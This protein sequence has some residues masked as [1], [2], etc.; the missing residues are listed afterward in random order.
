MTPDMMIFYVSDISSSARFYATVLGQEPQDLSPGFALFLLPNGLKIGLW[1]TGAVAPA[2]SFTGCGA[3]LVLHAA[4]EA[5]VEEAHSRWAAAGLPI[6]DP[7]VGQEFGFS[8][9]ATDPDGHRV[10]V[11]KAEG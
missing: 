6:L 8:F 5:E 4:T 10:R 2:A 1:K 3:E 11:L 9:V 7:P